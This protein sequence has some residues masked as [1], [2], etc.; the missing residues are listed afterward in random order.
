[1]L[2]WGKRRT[3]LQRNSEKKGISGF[4][5]FPKQN[6]P[7]RAANPNAVKSIRK[8]R[9]SAAKNAHVLIF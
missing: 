8:Q 4:A 1:M 5:S 9:P 3:K 6:A 7:P 2:L